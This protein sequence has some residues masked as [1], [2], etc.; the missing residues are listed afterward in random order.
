MTA[1]HSDLIP[2]VRAGGFKHIFLPYENE[3]DMIPL[4]RA[5]GFK[6]IDTDKALA[7]RAIPLVRAGG[8]KP[9]VGEGRYEGPLDPARKS[10]WI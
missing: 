4:V 5:G 10:G 7:I 1:S 8:F 3:D 6:L 2:L 9:E